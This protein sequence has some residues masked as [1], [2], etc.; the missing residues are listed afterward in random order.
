MPAQYIWTPNGCIFAS[1]F[2]DRAIGARGLLFAP[3]Y[4]GA[5]AAFGAG[6]V[7]RPAVALAFGA[8]ANSLFVRSSFG[9]YYFGDY[10]GRSYGGLGFQPWV[11]FAARN[12]D[13]HFAYERWANRNNAQWQSGLHATYTGRANG[14][15]PVPPRTFADQARSTA[16]GKTPATMTTLDQLRQ[17]GQRLVPVTA[18]QRAS[19]MQTVQQIVQRSADMTRSTMSRPSTGANGR[20]ATSASATNGPGRPPIQGLGGGGGI[21]SSIIQGLTQPRSG[22][23]PTTSFKPAP[24]ASGPNQP[25]SAGAATQRP[26]MNGV[27]QSLQSGGAASGGLRPGNV[28]SVGGRPGGM[29]SG[30]GRPGGMQSGGG[31]PGGMQ[32]GGGRPGGGGPRR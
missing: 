17:S 22:G 9:H 16:G 27:I 26:I 6:Y 29:Q 25:P 10:Y 13:P 11:G 23:G 8:V 24:S 19:Q 3:V 20:A 4:F 2:W 15:L 7:Y 14:T 5:R 32:S 12:Y 18:A 28:P 31:R 30:G 1:G 21:G